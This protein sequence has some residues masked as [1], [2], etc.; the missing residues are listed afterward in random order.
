M[1]NWNRWSVDKLTSILIRQNIIPVS[2][3]VVYYNQQTIVIIQ[4][5]H[6]DI[7]HFTKWNMC[8]VLSEL[9]NDPWL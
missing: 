5:L 9:Q 4:N 6:F 2:H 8:W 1:Q 7:L 3:Y